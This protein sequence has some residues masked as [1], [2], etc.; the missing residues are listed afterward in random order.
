MTT[1]RVIHDPPAAGG[2]NMAV[3]EMM[4]ESVAE[5]GE[6]ILRFYAWEEPTLSLGYFQALEYR[7]S[8]AASA[9]CPVVRRS[10]GGGAIVH[11]QELTYSIAVP[12][13]D[14]WSPAAT[15]LYE[16]MHHSLM[17]ALD[18]LGLAATLC[19]KTLHDLEAEFLCFQR[20]TK[21][22]VLVAGHKIAGSAQRRRQGAMLQHGSVILAQSVA[23]PE[24]LGLEQLGLTTSA[25]VLSAHW[26]D[27]LKR[28]WT[29]VKLRQDEWSTS[30][31]ASASAIATERFASSTWLTRRT[32]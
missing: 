1:L 29:D 26:P 13:T 7:Q 32:L 14:R 8:H 24:I 16:S 20:R 28:L 30:E 5:S 19:E 18:K 15:G 27:E 3:D 12:I 23:A 4:L 25:A 22:D 17:S 31:R 10:T 21:G 2:W 6:A 11:D 9:Q